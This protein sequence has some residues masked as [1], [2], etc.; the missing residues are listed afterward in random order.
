MIKFNILIMYNYNDKHT[1][2]N[3]KDRHMALS[4]CFILCFGM[5]QVHIMKKWNTAYNKQKAILK[6]QSLKV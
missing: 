3:Q 6:F 2:L 4:M 5:D 1:V